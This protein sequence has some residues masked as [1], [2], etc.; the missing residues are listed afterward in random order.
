MRGK[1]DVRVDVSLR[2]NLILRAM[3]EKGIKS[4]AALCRRA[5]IPGMECHV[6]LVVNMRQLPY[7]IPPSGGIRW[8]PW[9]EKIATALGLPPESLFSENQ[10]E[11]PFE[12]NR[13]HLEEESEKVRAMLTAG[14][15]YAL[16]DTIAER[17]ELLATLKAQLSQLRPREVKVLV[18]Y[19]G[20]DGVEGRSF[21]DV[22]KLLTPPRTRTRVQ[23]IEA[24]AL[25]KLRM[26]HHA[27]RLK[28]A[29]A[30]QHCG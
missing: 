18:L 21:E 17:K 15:H 20:L 5:G 12:K 13:I 26:P 24:G 9:V 2:N 30:L 23:Q 7:T 3:E 27:D 19:F 6:G 22:G 8:R 1:K 25:K 29:G 28:E 14:E 16:P 11:E 4:I 10:L